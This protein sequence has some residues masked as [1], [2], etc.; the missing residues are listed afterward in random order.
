MVREMPQVHYHKRLTYAIFSEACQTQ[1]GQWYTKLTHDG[2]SFSNLHTATR[3][4]FAKTPNTADT[5][6]CGHT[7][8][9]SFDLVK[10]KIGI[11]KN[12]LQ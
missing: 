1:L 7:D 2:F 5:I 3:E 10:F 6:F 12:G 11:R 8:N 4:L 9:S